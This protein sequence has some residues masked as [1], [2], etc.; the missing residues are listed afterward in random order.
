M[1]CV[2]SS[3]AA[4]YREIVSSSPL[5][6]LACLAPV[7]SHLSFLK[8]FSCIAVTTSLLVMATHD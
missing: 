6:L 8:W 5:G 2:G 4:A 7:V 3:L 1:G